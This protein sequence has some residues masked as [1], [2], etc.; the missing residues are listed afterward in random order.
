MVPNQTIKKYR[1]AW[2]LAIIALL[3]AC[4]VIN[5]EATST[6]QPDLQETQPPVE[7]TRQKEVSE[8]P[9]DSATVEK[10]ACDSNGEVKRF[11]LDSQLMNGEL[12]VSVFFPPCYDENLAGGYP[13]LY[14]LHG[15]EFD[16]NMWLNL[17]GGKLANEMVRTGAAQPFLMVF[18]YEEFYYRSADN[19]TFPDAILEEIIPFIESSFNVCAARECRAVGGISR[20]ASW[21]MRMGLENWDVFAAIGSHSLPTFRSDI[22][23]L[24]YWLDDI[25][26]ESVPLIYMDTGRFDPEVKRA[27]S[28]EQILS[29]KG[30]VHE[31]HL[32]EGR[33]TN[34]YWTTHMHEYLQWY[35]SAFDESADGWK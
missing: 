2:I 6:P 27:Y 4:Q 16:D 8:L 31:W 30:I 21:A 11:L 24:P 34:D 28:F 3:S 23:N 29:E 1:F 15:Q 33:H 18:P 13:A 5:P 19:N 20:G 35:A 22:S 9:Q 17:G 12:Y 32:N 26:D 10:K 7:V 14:L 25:P